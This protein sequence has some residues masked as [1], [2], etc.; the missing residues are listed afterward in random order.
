MTKVIKA[1]KLIP[2]CHCT[3]KYLNNLIEQ[4]HCHINLNSIYIF[5]LILI[6]HLIFTIIIEKKQCRKE[7]TYIPSLFLYHY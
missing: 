2:N 1:L 5:I 4:D 7:R 3:S 6:Y